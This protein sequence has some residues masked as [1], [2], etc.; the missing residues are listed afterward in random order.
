MND[1]LKS[2]EN[3]A[4]AALTKRA[5]A[6]VTTAIK[7]ASAK[8]GVSFSYLMEKAAAE[9]NFN[10]AIKAKT[11]SATGLFQFIESTWM[12]MVDRHG[13]KHGVDTAQSRSDLL[14]LRKNPALA[15]IMAAEFAADNKAYLQ[16]T[17]GG[18]ISNTELYFA[19]FMGAGGASA[20]LTQLK[21][22]PHDLAAQIFPKEAR[23]NRAVFYNADGSA[24]SFGE[25]YNFF[26]KKFGAST[27]A[28][29]Q[30]MAHKSIAQ[31]K[32][33]SYQHMPF[34]LKKPLQIVDSPM[35]SNKSNS[36][37]QLQNQINAFFSQPTGLGFSATNFYGT[38][39]T[40]PASLINVLR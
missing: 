32:E 24:R 29:P 36:L 13:S 7:N 21:Q 14:N 25:I 3:N 22:N 27:E 34:S 15:S 35:V 18:E 39:N 20:F 33:G 9:S 38:S 28:A 1:A 11:S 8:T 2:L 23:A 19:H 12:D 17:V 31:T 40:K 16:K 6:N 5:G 4:L 37:Y 26:D 30:T 10:P